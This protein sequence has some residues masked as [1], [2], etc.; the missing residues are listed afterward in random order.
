MTRAKP[1]GLKRVTSGV[2]R[3]DYIL[4]G[5]FIA[6]GTYAIIGPP[7]SGKTVFAN[8][9]CFNH[10]ARAGGR[11]LYV[12][13]LA[14][15]H[16]KMIRHLGTMSFFD[17]KRL[18]DRLNYVSGYKALKEG[19]LRGLLDLIRK[20]LK[21]QRP[22][23]M[24]IDGLQVAQ[25]CSKDRHDYDEFLHDLQSFAAITETTTLLLSPVGKAPS[26]EY[27][28]HVIADGIIELSYQLFGPRAVRELTVHKFRGTDYL[29]GRHEVEIS[30]D[31]VQVHPRTEIQYDAPPESATETR[32]RMAFGV[33]R[34]DQMLKG[35][36]LSGTTT[37]LLGS[38]GTGK[39]MLGLSFVAEGARQGQRGVYFGFYEPPPRLIEKAERIGIP[40]KKYVKKGLI[41]LV[42]QPPLEHFMDSL[43]EQLLE[44]LRAGGTSKKRRLFVDGIE[45]F[46]AAA[47]YA[48]RMP[49]FLS[50]LSNQ[51]RML[52]VTT[53]VSEELAL[54]KPEVDLPHPELATVN[55]GVILLRYVELGSDVHRLISILKM[56]ESRY[57]TSICNFEI[58]D[59]GL[60][61]NGPFDAERVLTGRPQLLAGQASAP[62]KGGR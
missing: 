35:G 44:K 61:V 9:M 13:L 41:E 10:I 12:T 8:Q 40:L 62:G 25:K 36:L 33:E 49:R 43:A 31:G 26:G 34:L 28:E 57:D 5:G 42:W 58:T 39:T 16:G 2:T 6:G 51:L 7:G 4:K 1:A 48:E 23:L 47:V 20:L 11:C 50:A 59:E 53:V 46:R 14:E 24:V 19:G 60:V 18:P 37:T 17:A 55:E 52:D 45:G 30:H 29:L 32:L 3:L 21:E 38:P 15:T 56:R 27:V 54:F 22:T